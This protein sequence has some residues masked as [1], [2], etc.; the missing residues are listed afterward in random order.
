MY[1]PSTRCNAWYSTDKYGR[2]PVLLLS[3][4]FLTNFL[5]PCSSRSSLET[6]PQWPCGSF[7]LHFPSFCSPGIFATFDKK[8]HR[9]TD[10][11]KRADFN[12]HDHRC[13]DKGNAQ[14]G[15][16]VGGNSLCS[17]IYHRP[18][19]GIPHICTF[20]PARASLR[21]PFSQ[22]S[23]CSRYPPLSALLKQCE[24]RFGQHYPNIQSTHT[25]LRPC[26]HFA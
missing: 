15:S 7:P 21:A 16:R 3:M 18:S 24:S 8:D 17:W 1:L 23:T 20:T 25:R 9:W 11:G 6:L 19:P 2:R 26:L 4:V 10:R 13:H 14:Q 22:A 12:C 5:I